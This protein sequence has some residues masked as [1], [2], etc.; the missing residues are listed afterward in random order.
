MPR[1]AGKVSAYCLHKAS[2]R[3][4]VR[5]VGKDHYL[6]GPCGSPE[7]HERYER[8]IAEWWASHSRAVTQ[9]TQPNR[10]VAALT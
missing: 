7:S 8:L 5:L 2:G 10:P 6:G 9:T 1:L 3:A 4:V